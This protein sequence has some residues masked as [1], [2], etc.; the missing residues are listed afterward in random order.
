MDGVAFCLAA[1]SG[2]GSEGAGVTVGGGLANSLD[3]AS[4]RS[5]LHA[6][7]INGSL[8]AANMLLEAGALVHVR[9]GLG[10]TALYYAAR[11]GHEDMVD[12]LVKTGANLGGSDIEGGF[13]A[14]AVKKATHARDERLINIWKKAGADVRNT[15]I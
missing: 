6:A 3:P 15:G 2:G 5:P 8:R 9:D 14:L 13:V 12:L 10:H 7:A 4:G 1:E 11:Q